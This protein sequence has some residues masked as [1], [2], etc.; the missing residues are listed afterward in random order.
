MKNVE[1]GLKMQ[2]ES[3]DEPFAQKIPVSGHYLNFRKTSEILT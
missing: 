1:N 2:E 3:W